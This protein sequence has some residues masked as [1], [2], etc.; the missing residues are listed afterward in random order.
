MMS[1]VSPELVRM[2]GWALL[3][4]VWQGALV[5]L[6]LWALLAVCTR[7]TVRY[8]V[9][10][11][12]LVVMVAL[13]AA[14]LWFLERPAPVAEATSAEVLAPAPAMSV[15]GPAVHHAHALVIPAE[16]EPSQ[17]MLWLVRIWMV[18]VILF[19][20]RGAGGF[21]VMQRL[22]KLATSP[23]SGELLQVCETVR[24]RMGIT[25]AV[26]FCRSAALQVPAV[27]GGLRPIVLLPISA[28]AGLSDAQI[29]A[30]VAHELAHIQRLDYFVNLFQV[31]AETVLFYHPA[32]W[33]VNQR[34]RSERENCCDDVAIA[35]C[36]NRLE[37]VRA[38]THL[39][40]LRITPQFAMA[41][42][43]SPLKARVRRLL[44]MAE[45]SEGVR[46]GSSVLGVMVV[47][48]L[49][50]AAS[51]LAT[52]AKVQADKPAATPQ[53]AQP[54]EKPATDAQAA[55]DAQ[56]NA[57]PSAA[58]P[59]IAPEAATEPQAAQEPDAATEPMVAHP[60]VSTINVPAVHVHVPEVNVDVPGQHFNTGTFSMNTPEVHLHVPGVNVDV[61]GQHFTTPAFAMNMPAMNMHVPA[62]NVHVPAIH[63]NSMMGQAA[64]GSQAQASSSYIEDMKGA[65]LGNLTVDELV[66]MK[67]QGITPE[68]VRGMR[69]AGVNVDADEL[70]G[71]K[72]QGV[73]PEYVKQMRAA[74]P[75][76]DVDT[77]IG[78][79]VQ[80]VTTEYA[81]ELSKLGIKADADDLIGLKVQGVTPEYVRDMKATGINFDT[82]ELVGMKVQGVTPAYVSM[83][84]SAGLGKIDTD[85]IIGAKTMG[86]TP[87]FIEKAKSHGFKDL[88]L[89]KLIELKTTGIL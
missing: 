26:R 80:G 17:S 74:Y 65:G 18:G 22:R 61:P 7:T 10:V 57:K 68:Y 44:G 46:T 58:I 85:D 62:V 86:I 76:I 39:E 20:L 71:L 79:K 82:D 40:S 54:W 50:L 43:G 37:Y 81:T 64:A 45:E 83:L 32:V 6:A 51:S 78:F 8:A 53:V 63:L 34:I 14:T 66:A 60:R 41:A 88:D 30:I 55:S 36:G 73:T 87:E 59:V 31:F 4:F 67:I 13:P 49:V 42:N 27:V 5:A 19:A 77:I 33:W 38:L 84:K 11:I 25:W 12:A 48:A 72:V 16:S 69:A 1:H 75:G 28:I 52:G 35:V 9:C 24:D 3:H 70:V 2:I 89:D 23:A 29:E 56:E 47:A 21:V 15:A